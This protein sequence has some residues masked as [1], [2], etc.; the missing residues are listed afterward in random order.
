MDLNKWQK[1]AKT[2]QEKMLMMFLVE[3][4]TII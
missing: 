4:L 3:H 2:V 1:I